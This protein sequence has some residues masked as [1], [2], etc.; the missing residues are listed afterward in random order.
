[1]SDE[2]DERWLV[3]KG[4]RW[5]RTDPSLPEDVV[6]GLTS[7]LG[8]GRSGVRSARLHEDAEAEALARRRIGLA[9]HGLGERGPAWWDEPEA[10]RLERAREALRA[11]EE[12]DAPED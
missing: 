6:A 5:R 9:K 8:R 7:H 1:M 3:V 12:L 4:R 10:D 2:D 11:L